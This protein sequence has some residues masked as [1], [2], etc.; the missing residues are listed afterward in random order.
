[1]NQQM[2]HTVL[3]IATIVI[4]MSCIV[5]GHMLESGWFAQVERWPYL[6][7]IA[8]IAMV[9]VVGVFASFILVLG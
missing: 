9:L 1:M 7:L 6:D 5:L 3:L 2:S 8:S 4:G